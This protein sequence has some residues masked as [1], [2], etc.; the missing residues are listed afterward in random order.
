MRR[1]QS[2]GVLPI[3]TPG[4]AGGIR[5]PYLLTASLKPIIP[6]SIFIFKVVFLCLSAKAHFVRKIPS[7]A[8]PL[9]SFG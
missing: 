6:N 9:Y 4:G 2:V 8:N 3:D 7:S 1:K 5:T